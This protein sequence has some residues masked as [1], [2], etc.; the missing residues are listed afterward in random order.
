MKT[1][2]VS[3]LF[4][5]LFS[6]GTQYRFAT[7]EA[8]AADSSYVYALPFPEGKSHLVVQGYN[9]RFSHRGRLGLDFKMKKGSPVAA[10]RSGVVAALQESNTRG[11]IKRKYYR[12]ANSVT[13][14]HSDGTLSFYG[15]LQHNGVDVNIGDTVQQG[16]VIARSGSTGYSLFPHLHFSVWQPSATGRRMLLPVR[17]NTRKGIRYLRPGRWYRACPCTHR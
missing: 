17:F 2:L 10:A 4:V 7:R 12:Q 1:L 6:C 9:S 16:Q 3:I 13:V 5:F 14:R 8:A 11:G 15:H